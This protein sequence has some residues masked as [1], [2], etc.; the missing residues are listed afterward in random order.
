MKLNICFFTIITTT[1]IFLIIYM[2]TIT[3]FRNTIF[4]LNYSLKQASKE[5]TNFSEKLV[6]TTPTFVLD[7]T[8]N[9]I[10]IEDK[11][12]ETHG[13]WMSLSNHTY[14]KISASYYFLDLNFIYLNLV[15]HLNLGVKKLKFNLNVEVNVW[16]KV[17][18]I[19][20]LSIDKYDF[21]DIESWAIP[22]GACTIKI[23]FNLA[24][25]IQN[26]IGYNR[27]LASSDLTI[28]RMHLTAINAEKNESWRNAIE[29]K[30]KNSPHHIDSE[31]NKKN[32]SNSSNTLV[33]SKILFINDERKFT[34]FKLWTYLNKIIG[35]DRLVGY[36][37]PGFELN[38]KQWD[39]IFN[40]N[41]DFLEIKQMKCFPN[42]LNSTEENRYFGN[43]NPNAE[44]FEEIFKI[45]DTIAYIV[46]HECYLDNF[47]KF[48]Y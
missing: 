18:T 27:T 14:F 41:K 19:Q 24:E 46:L 38:E 26:E 1:C 42:L 37:G 8:P 3:D 4:R 25:A 31:V 44:G 28:I 22:Y 17:F 34:D 36:N 39:F 23:D 30:L 7:N 6:E 40:K 47:D 9:P 43:L 20:R 48:R 12:C 5:N 33:C 10:V 13:D 11:W 29:L 21:F 45:M 35:Y 15:R 2:S 16:E 32:S